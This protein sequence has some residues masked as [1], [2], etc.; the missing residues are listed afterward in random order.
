MQSCKVD[1]LMDWRHLPPLASLRAFAAFAE[2]GNVV[3]AGEALG[4]SHAA[5]SQQ[6]K[7]LEQHLDA[8]LLDRS[9]RALKMTATGEQLAAALR[10]G[11]ETMGSA[12]TEITGAQADR[13]LHISTTPTFAAAWL[14][15]RLPK[16]RMQCP[17]VDLMLDPTPAVVELA[18]DGFDLAIRYGNGDWPGVDVVPLL[19]SSTVVVAAP[20]LVGDGPVGDLTDYP[21]MEEYGT[22]ETS[23]WLGHKDRP[24]VFPKGRISVP[25]KSGSGRRAGRAGDRR[26]GSVGRRAGHRSRAVAHTGRG[27]EPQGG[28]LCGH[29]TGGHAP[30]AQDI[31][32][33]AEAR[34]GRDRLI[35]TGNHPDR[36]R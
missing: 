30:R 25:R 8:A 27:Q 26:I 29:A 4:V 16:F 15:P 28:I 1:L 22:S 34:G 24:K 35:R 6:L 32:Q 19:M 11:F 9:G 18:P 31:C 20:S 14:M 36:G 3:D 2:T 17:G 10:S 5:V 21:W 23:Q 7:A 13:P 12:V 33:L